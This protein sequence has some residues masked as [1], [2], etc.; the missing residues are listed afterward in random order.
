MLTNLIGY[1]FILL[2]EVVLAFILYLNIRHDIRHINKKI[3]K[4]EEYPQQWLNSEIKK[5]NCLNKN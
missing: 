1:L 3:I 5:F 4:Y 2:L